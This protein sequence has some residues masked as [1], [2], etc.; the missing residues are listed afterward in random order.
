MGLTTSERRILISKF[1]AS[2]N[3]EVMKNES[4]RISCFRICGIILILDDTGDE[5]IKP[6]GCTKLPLTIPETINLVDKNRKYSSEILQ[7]EACAHGVTD[8]DTDI[9]MA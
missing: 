6:Q 4:S 1:V 3:D 9:H 7:S 2:V 5:L 8:E